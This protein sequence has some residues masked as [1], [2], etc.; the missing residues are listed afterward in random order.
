M[1]KILTFTKLGS[2]LDQQI[3]TACPEAELIT[4]KE[5]EADS[6]IPEADIIIGFGGMLNWAHILPLA[7]KC[8][9]VHTLSAGVDRLTAQP[10]FVAGDTILTNS[11]G[12]HGIPMGEH[13][14]GIILGFTRKLF[15]TYDNQK[16]HRW[17]T[18]IRGLEEIAGKT[19]VIVGLGAVG[20][21]IAAKLKAMDMQVIGVK[22][23]VSDLPGIDKVYGTDE[24][25]EALAQGD[26]VIV[27]LPV[28][29]ETRDLFN[30]ERFKRMKSNAIFINVSRG[31]TV[32]DDDLA[33]A[34]NDG[35]IAGASLD[36]F[37]TEPLPADDPLWDAP[38]LI[39]TPHDA[40][41]SPMYLPRTIGIFCENLKVFPDAAKMQNVV[42]KVRGY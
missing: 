24:L 31:E 4:V 5:A 40:A 23:H 26:V 30:R 25:D 34:L 32:V 21:G 14:L 27:A 33:A 15:H 19:A 13:C 12:I 22:Q 38:N 9:W 10:D 7:K 39:V 42:D 2:K 3:K 41:I 20:I 18:G 17:E 36:V 35:V 11:K 28:T 29:P 8:R 37:R 1:P 16:A 6:I